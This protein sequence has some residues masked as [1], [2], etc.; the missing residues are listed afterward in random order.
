MINQII[1]FGK[2]GFDYKIYLYHIFNSQNFQHKILKNLL[3]FKNLFFY[4]QIYYK[5][6][7][8]HKSR[9]IQR[10]LCH[11][12]MNQNILYCATNVYKIK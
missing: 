4:F 12:Y 7:S 2:M 5:I 11:P 10:N 9:K 8:L 3:N 6:T 1:I